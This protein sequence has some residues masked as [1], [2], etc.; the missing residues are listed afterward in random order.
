MHARLPGPWANDEVRGHLI[1]VSSRRSLERQRPQ[2]HCLV[3]Y[4]TIGQTRLQRSLHAPEAIQRQAV[5][6][7]DL[8]FQRQHRQLHA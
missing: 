8:Q 4:R 6:V 7:L 1:G 5:L 2:R 3:L